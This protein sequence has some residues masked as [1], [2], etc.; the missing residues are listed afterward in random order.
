MG[1]QLS[2]SG[3]CSQEASDPGL[4]ESGRAITITFCFPEVGEHMPVGWF[5]LLHS[6]LLAQTSH[7]FAAAQE[8]RQWG[9]PLPWSVC[10]VK[11]LE[12]KPEGGQS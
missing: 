2:S 7:C 6:L 10:T 9:G 12:T 5:A 3:S 1:P 8:S 11:Q 4:L